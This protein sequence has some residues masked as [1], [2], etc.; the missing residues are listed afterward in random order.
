MG[1]LKILR[2]LLWGS[3]LF[4]GWRLVRRKFFPTPHVIPLAMRTVRCSYC[5]VYLPEKEALAKD[6]LWYCSR[7]HLE[8]ANQQ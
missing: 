4:L 2:L 7:A 6:Q 1:A 8:S 5:G 3:V